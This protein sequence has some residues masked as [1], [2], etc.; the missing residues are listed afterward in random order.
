MLALFAATSQPAAAQSDEVPLIGQR[1]ALVAQAHAVGAVPSAQP[2]QVAVQLRPRNEAMLLAMAAA[3]SGRAPLSAAHARSLFA[4]SAADRRAVADHLRAAGMTVDRM[5]TMTVWASG[6]SDAAERAFGTDLE[7]Y[8]LPSGRSFHAPDSALHLP[9]QVAGLVQSVGGLDTSALYLSHAQAGPQAQVA[10]SCGGPTNVKNSFGGLLPADMAAANAYDSQALIDAGADGDGEAIAFLE[11]SNYVH[12]DVTTYKSCFG[13]ATPVSDVN[14]SGGTST[15]T[16]N[17][18]VT[19]DIEAA[20][21]A[22]PHLAHAYVYMAPNGPV[23]ISAMVERMVDDSG[24]NGVHEISISW[25]LCEAHTSAGELAAQQNALAYAAVQGISVFVASGDSGSSTCGPPT[26]LLNTDATSSSPFATGVGG[27]R[28][29]PGAS[30]K[31]RVWNHDF[32]GGGGGLSHVWPMPSWQHTGSVYA[33][34][35]GTPCGNTGGYCRQVPDIA[36]DSDPDTG[37]IVYCSSAD[38]GHQGWTLIGGTSGAAPLMAG[39]TADMNEYSLANGGQRLGY[40]NPFLYATAASSPGDFFDVTSGNIDVT[41]GLLGGKYAAGAGYDMASGLGSIDAHALAAA[42][43]AWSGSAPSAADTVVTS[44]QSRSTLLVGGTVTLS[45][46][47]HEVAGNVPMAGSRVWIE[48]RYTGLAETSVKA[49]TD[50]SGHW[51]ATIKPGRHL[52]WRALY[53][54]DED[55][56]ASGSTFHTITVTPKLSIAASRT[57][58]PHGVT[59]TLSGFSTPNMSGAKVALQWRGLHGTVWHGLGMATVGTKGGYSGRV[60]SGPGSYYFR[61]HYTG[62]GTARW[63]SANSPAKLIHVT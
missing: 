49:I 34:S 18:E 43:A 6:P 52:S 57:T 56:A 25:G 53:M 33:D 11:Y 62:G 51:T 36:L 15:L 41:G 40:A 12:S 16:G 29:V 46:M 10:P 50:G 59:F 54:G 24:A 38:C 35:S 55:H 48:L 8:R 4:P 44:A 63:L 31:E 19:L 45:G 21:S 14:V 1:S 13:L 61:W 7:R 20:L 17:G 37:Y 5:G 47:L 27:T 60:S 9:V 2:V 22:A 26:P 32:S 42:L 58:V 28:L 39:L 23:P 30:P 3:S